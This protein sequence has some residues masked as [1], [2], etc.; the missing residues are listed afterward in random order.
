MQ[1]AL[2]QSA[3]PEP[4][5]VSEEIREAVHR[6]RRLMAQLHAEI[7]SAEPLEKESSR[8]SPMAER[9]GFEPPV[10]L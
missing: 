2:E 10:E 3:A 7:G 8:R 1:A 5:Q 6:V 4:E 9:G